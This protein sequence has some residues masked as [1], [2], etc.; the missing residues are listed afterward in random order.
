MKISVITPTFNSEKTIE[1]NIESIKNQTY[2]N[3]EQIFIDGNS[4]DSTIKKIK[5]LKNESDILIS[6]V[7]EGIYDAINK[8]IKLSTGDIIGILNSD[9]FM[10]SNCVHDLIANEFKSNNIDFVYGDIRYIDEKDKTIRY[11]KSKNYSKKMINFGWMPPHPSLYVSKKI[12]VDIGLY[13]LN[14]K[15]SSDYD[16]MIR[17]LSAK[18]L[19]YKYIDKCLIDMMTGG[20]SNRSLKSIYKKSCEDFIILK[21]YS[22]NP[23]IA[24]FYKNISKLSQFFK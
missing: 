2:G 12:F 10:H 9:D 22:K 13:N 15:I 6:E 17:L 18:G 11:W 24:L 4:S 20:V 7:D 23:L 19:S 14:Y 16:F 8:G 21:N 5:N 1:R 3:Y